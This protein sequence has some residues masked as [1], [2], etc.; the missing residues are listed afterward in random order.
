MHLV[1]LPLQK[2]TDAGFKLQSI[3]AFLNDTKLMKIDQKGI[4]VHAV[5]TDRWLY[6]PHGYVALHLN[7]NNWE[8]VLKK[9]NDRKTTF[10]YEKEHFGGLVHAPA[11][12]PKL[13]QEVS[14]DTWAELDSLHKDYFKG[15]KAGTT[16]LASTWN[17]FSAEVA[18]A[19]AEKK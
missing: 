8:L 10:T 6:V 17:R 11:W 15:D 4:E 18:A 19:R 13:L 16:V 5:P 3:H 9:M 2:A 7:T 14:D 1:V 12:I